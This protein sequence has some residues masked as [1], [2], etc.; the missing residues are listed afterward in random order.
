MGNAV[1]I[2]YPTD[3]NVVM[4]DIATITNPVQEVAQEVLFTG[5]SEMCTLSINN[6]NN[7]MNVISNELN[8]TAADYPVLREDQRMNCLIALSDPATVALH[9][10]KYLYLNC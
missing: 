9:T 3:E 2:D 6:L 1:A 4:L 10:N 5:T 7:E 8:Y